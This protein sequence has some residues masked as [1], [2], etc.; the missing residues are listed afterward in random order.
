MKRSRCLDFVSIITRETRVRYLERMSGVGTA[1]ENDRRPP[2][3]TQSSFSVGAEEIIRISTSASGRKSSVFALPESN[4]DATTLWVTTRDGHNLLGRRVQ[5]LGV[6]FH[7]DGGRVQLQR[8]P[9]L[10]LHVAQEEPL[11]LS[12][13]SRTPSPPSPPSP[14]SFSAADPIRRNLPP[15]L[16]SSSCSAPSKLRRGDDDPFAAQTSSLV[17][18]LGA[19]H[20]DGDPGCLNAGLATWRFWFWFWFWFAAERAVVSPDVDASS[21]PRARSS[22]ERTGRTPGSL[23]R[24]TPSPRISSSTL[25]ASLMNTS[26]SLK[27]MAR[28]RARWDPFRVDDSRDPPLDDRGEPDAAAPGESNP[29]PLRR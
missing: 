2:F 3:C 29:R 26:A 20:L 12:P 19:P 14:F 6:G 27:L 1:A 17:S 9:R 13:R 18:G 4:G 11:A 8:P 10:R 15:P 16:A 5:S 21:N 25:A 28:P 24:T 7:Q 22:D 23:E